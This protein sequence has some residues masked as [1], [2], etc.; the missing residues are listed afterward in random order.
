MVGC[1]PSERGALSV[2][3]MSDSALHCTLPPDRNVALREWIVALAQR[4]RRYGAGM[5]HPKLRRA[6]P[7]P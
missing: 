1:G 2:V 6:E 5:I 3:R 4:H 7:G